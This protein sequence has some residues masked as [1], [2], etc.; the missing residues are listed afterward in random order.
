MHI[1]LVEPEYQG[2]HVALHLNLLINEFYKRKWEISILTYKKSASSEAYRLIDTKIFRQINF[3]YIKEISFYN[4]KNIFYLIYIQTSKYFNII[5]SIKK[6]LLKN[7]IDH[8][9]F[10]T[11]DHI[12][13]VLAIL[14]NFSLKVRFSLML[15]YSKVYLNKNINYFNR[16]L[17]GVKKKLLF[18][19]INLSYLTNFFVLDLFL[20]KFIKK[21]QKK[22]F[23]KVIYTPDP[24]QLN[25][26]FSQKFAKNYLKIKK[27]AFIILIYGAI[28]MSKGI[29][30]LISSLQYLNNN[31]IKLIIAGKQ[32]DE[33][34]FF[35][36]LDVNKELIKSG[37]VIIYEGFKNY[38]DEAIL[39]SASDIVW[40]G[41]DNNFSGSSG[42]LHQAGLAKKPVITNRLGLLGY[43]NKKYKIGSVVNLSNVIDIKNK[44]LYL[45]R[46]KKIR[47]ILG[48]NNHDLSKI[49]SGK[50][51]ARTIVNKI[52]NVK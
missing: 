14:G 32:T 11:G 3:F 15:I 38:K 35:L 2:H 41:Y 43:L 23:Y 17:L 27:N 16:L 6:I 39:F 42:V 50:N 10:V 47:Y 1:L 31:K 34:Q 18:K 29:K 8:I 4:S 33:V 36:N 48:K 12:D 46:N 22:N 25:F 51:F 52:S 49:H 37:Q 26:F 24:G 9:Y 45:Y 44:I 19:L 5:I 28:K 13:K 21:N 30:E 40:V 7:D 20:F